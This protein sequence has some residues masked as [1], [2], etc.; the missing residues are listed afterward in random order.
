MAL[1]IE[2]DAEEEPR[3]YMDAIADIVELHHVSLI[4][5]FELLMRLQT[6]DSVLF[7]ILG[8]E[9]VQP[10]QIFPPNFFTSM[11]GR[12]RGSTDTLLHSPTPSAVQALW[13]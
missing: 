4:N 8:A 9:D 11:T 6:I 2:F 1:S 12:S 13:F 3:D 10:K 5:S 7:D